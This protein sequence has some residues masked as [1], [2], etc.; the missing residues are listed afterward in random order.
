LIG[1]Y[2]SYTSYKI[3]ENKV[4]NAQNKGKKRGIFPVLSYGSLLVFVLRH[5]LQ[6]PQCGFYL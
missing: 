1:F 2:Q 5:V 4:L 3:I 6:T